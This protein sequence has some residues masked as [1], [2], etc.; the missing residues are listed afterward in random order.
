MPR[1]KLI[2]NLPEERSDHAAAVHGLDAHLV[3]VDFLAKI[4]SKL[5]YHP[6]KPA[7]A[8]VWE[9]ARELL[10]EIMQARDVDLERI[11]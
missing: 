3:L 11:E 7:E 8:K 10:H 1:A 4:R 5:K 2:F 6:M 9:H